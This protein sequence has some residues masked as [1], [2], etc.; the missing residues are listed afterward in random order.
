MRIMEL[1]TFLILASLVFFFFILITRLDGPN[2]KSQCRDLIRWIPSC[3]MPEREEAH[4]HTGHRNKMEK[5]KINFLTFEEK[6][7]I[8]I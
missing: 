3:G 8:N 7:K 1:G 5:I 4:T 2:E 6:M